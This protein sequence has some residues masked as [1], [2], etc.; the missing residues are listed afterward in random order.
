MPRY[1]EHLSRRTLLGAL[2]VAGAAGTAAAVAAA[3]S[4]RPPD[5]G[6]A[7]GL[8]T[9]QAE[10]N[11]AGRAEGRLVYLG[12]FG[13]GITMARYGGGTLTAVGTFDGVG[14]PSYLALAP[15]GRVLYALD[16]QRDGTV[17]ALAVG[18]RGTLHPLG[19]A[20]STG[21]D[22]PTHLSVHPGGRYLLTANYGS[23]SVAVHPIGA[24]GALGERTD[25]VRHQ[26]SG[27]DPERQRGPHAHQ[28]LTDPRGRF[29]LAVDL[30]TDSV[31][32]Y[33]LDPDRGRLTPVAQA[34]TA[35][36][37][38]PRHLAFHP[39]GRFAYLVGELDGTLTVAGYDPVRGRLV[40]RDS[41]A[42]LPDGVRPEE[43][44]YPAGVAVSADGRFVYVSNRGHDS[45]ARF[46]VTDGGARLRLLDTVPCGGSYPRYLGLSP[47][48]RL[49]FTG[50][51]RSG[52]VGVFRV[53]PRGG[54][55]RPVGEPFATGAPVCVLP[56]PEEGL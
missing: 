43:R 50:N 38:G 41:W 46:A 7:R 1:A 33:R 10:R 3:R 23:G 31:H 53:D 15:S 18:D 11:G 6:R 12:T 45:V 35:P 8:P 27:P 42:T 24:D 13:A 16:E 17:R 4:A 52:T 9:E 14:D 44:N 49:L 34:R 26:G 21:G 36:G 37:A 2:G 56:L 30:G 19:R 5:T 20:R 29:V 25:L 40:L 22:S 32:S 39:G 48:G 55:L 54:E 28:V 51:Q 47:S